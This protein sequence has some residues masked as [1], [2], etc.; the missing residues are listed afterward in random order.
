MVIWQYLLVPVHDRYT[1]Q[2]NTALGPIVW[3]VYFLLFFSVKV[4]YIT[5]VPLIATVEPSDLGDGASS[6]SCEC[7]GCWECGISRGGNSW[8]ATTQGDSVLFKEA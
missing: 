8:E 6:N 3:C 1:A 4:F 2:T 5:I 7:E